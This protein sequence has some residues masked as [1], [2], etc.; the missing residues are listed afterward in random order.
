M[1][2]NVKTKGH[3]DI[4][5]ITADVESAVVEEKIK[6]GAVLVFVVGST[7]AITTMEYEAGVKQDFKNMLESIAPEGFDYEH[8]KKWGD[9]NGAAHLRSA[10]VGTHFIAPVED[11]ALVLGSWQQIV[12]IDFDE[13]PRQREVIVK[14]IS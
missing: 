11:G 3:T 2:F 12:L 7:A 10:L 8:H 9:Q 4:I 13:K 1:M 5:D 14:G 6:N